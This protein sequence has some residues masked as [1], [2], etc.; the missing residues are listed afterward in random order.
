MR[1][2]SSN[3]ANTNTN[4]GVGQNV[5][6]DQDR[7]MVSN[8]DVED[9]KDAVEALLLPSV[10]VRVR[11]RPRTAVNVESFHVHQGHVVD[12]TQSVHGN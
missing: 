1:S 9:A 12:T 10:D 4:M 5:V 6:M 11:P 2:N 8:M 3:N 7:S